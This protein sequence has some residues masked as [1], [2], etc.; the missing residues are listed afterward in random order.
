MQTK[1]Q[2]FG[3]GSMGSYSYSFSPMEQKRSKGNVSAL[4]KS[5]NLV[6]RD[7]VDSE[8]ARMF[9]SSNLPFHLVR[10]LHYVNP[11]A[12]VA[13]NFLSGYLPPGIIN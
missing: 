3:S 10:N 6:L 8:I 2:S 9:C 5:F 1:S 13:N 4:E 12:L 11:F 7:Q